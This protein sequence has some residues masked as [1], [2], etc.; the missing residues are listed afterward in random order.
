[1]STGLN[2]DLQKYWKGNW[3]YKI[4]RGTRPQ[5]LL[6]KGKVSETTCK[7]FLKDR[8]TTFYLQKGDHDE[9]ETSNV[10][11]RHKILVLSFS[12]ISGILSSPENELGSE[13]GS[14]T[15]NRYSL[16]ESKSKRSL[17]WREKTPLFVNQLFT[18]TPPFDPSLLKDKRR[19]KRE[20]QETQNQEN[21]W[22]GIPL[23]SLSL[24]IL[25]IQR[26]S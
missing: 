12:A 20:I 26:W 6:I 17:T 3:D 24:R 25:G 1:M 7:P 4:L 18:S 22:V 21:L 16:G 11:R 14:E 9:Q 8:F 5:N 19:S 13:K 23:I 10:D 15:D 2:R